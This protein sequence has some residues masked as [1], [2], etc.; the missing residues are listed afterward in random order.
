MTTGILRNPNGAH[1]TVTNFATGLDADGNELDLTD[2][3]ITSYQAG[4]TI[5]KGQALMIVAPTATAG[6]TVVTMTT[7]VAAPDADV[8]RFAGVA[9]EAGVAGDQI[10]VGVCGAFRILHDASDNPAVYDLVEL[11]QTSNGDFDVVAGTPVDDTV[12]VGYFL[13]VTDVTSGSVDTALAYI[14]PITTRF[15]IA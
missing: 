12:V 1:R 10:Q 6:I 13:G 15:G 4:G 2:R 14:G 5:V 11:P 3:T 9:L 7:A 8:W